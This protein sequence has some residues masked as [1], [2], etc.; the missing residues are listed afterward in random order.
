[1]CQALIDDQAL[2]QR[3]ERQDHE[4]DHGHEGELAALALEEAFAL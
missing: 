2:H 1:M 3:C 4:H